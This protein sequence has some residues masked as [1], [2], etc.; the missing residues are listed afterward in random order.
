MLGNVIEWCQE[1]PLLYRPDRAG[2]MIDNINIQEYVDINP[3][4]LRGGAFN[5]RPSLVRSAN[6]Y[7]YAPAYRDASSRVPP[8]QDLPLIHFTA[9]PL[10]AFLICDINIYIN[11]IMFR[12]HPYPAQPGRTQKSLAAAHL[13]VDSWRCIVDGKP[14]LGHRESVRRRYIALRIIC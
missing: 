11:C 1:R 10:A 2:T 14:G 8:R 4:L 6:R 9:L 12:E 7:W 3:R 5:D 13:A